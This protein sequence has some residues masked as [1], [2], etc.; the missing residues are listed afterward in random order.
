MPIPSKLGF[1][2]GKSVLIKLKDNPYD[3]FIVSDGKHIP[4]ELKSQEVF[5]S[6]PLSNIR[7]HQLTGLQEMVDLGCLT[8]ILINQRRIV[9]EGKTVSNNRAWALDFRSWDSLLK[10]LG[11]RKSIPAKMFEDGRWFTEVPR[12]H[13]LSN[14]DK[15]VLVWDLRV[16]LHEK[17]TTNN[18]RTMPWYRHFLHRRDRTTKG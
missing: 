10:E 8:Y 13:V 18:P 17:D 15:K 14:D 4:L 1:R 3:G 11:G 12:T 9:K 7:D 5:G 16:I 2:G 6:F